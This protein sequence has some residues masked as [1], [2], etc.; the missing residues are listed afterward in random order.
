M[1]RPTSFPLVPIWCVSYSAKPRSMGFQVVPSPLDIIQS[2]ISLFL[3]GGCPQNVEWSNGIMSTPSMDQPA[4]RSNWFLSLINYLQVGVRS[5]RSIQHT[6]RKKRQWSYTLYQ[7]TG[8]RIWN[9]NWSNQHHFGLLRTAHLHHI[10]SPCLPPLSSR[11]WAV[12]ALL[13]VTE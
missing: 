13:C 4:H 2:D 10:P 3:F 5:I 11:S 12:C 6:F 9:W 1:P 8:K 7:E